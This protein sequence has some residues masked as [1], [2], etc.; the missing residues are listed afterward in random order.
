MGGWEALGHAWAAAARKVAPWEMDPWSPVLTLGQ[1]QVE[2]ALSLP[3]SRTKQ[4]A[5]DPVPTF[6]CPCVPLGSQ[7]TSHDPAQYILSLVGG[8]GL[9]AFPVQGSALM[10]AIFAS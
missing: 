4:T 10:L 9:P 1:G 6:L 2:Q 5:E 8:P 3:L 7:P